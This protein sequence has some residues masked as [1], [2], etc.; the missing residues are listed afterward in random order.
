MANMVAGGWWWSSNGESLIIHPGGGRPD[1]ELSVGAV[2]F[3]VGR[4]GQGVNQSQ[5]PIGL[6]HR[7]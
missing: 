4:P 5:K 3:K 6:L 7:P 1:F 2:G